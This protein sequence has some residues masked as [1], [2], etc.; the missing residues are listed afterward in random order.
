MYQPIQPIP[1]MTPPQYNQGYINLT[2][3]IGNA[4]SQGNYGQA[5][6]GV[7]GGQA[8]MDAY[9]AISN[10]DYGQAAGAVLGIPPGVIKAA[11]GIFGSSGLTAAQGTSGLAT[12]GGWD[13][14]TG[15]IAGS[16][17][18]ASILPEGMTSFLSGIFGF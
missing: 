18:T 9:K 13:A 6:G 4:F 10:G 3:N 15:A 5:I 12:G 8:G 17:A 1:G 11:Q 14:A 2:K 16:D 7:L